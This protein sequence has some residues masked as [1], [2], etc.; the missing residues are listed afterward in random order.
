MLNAATTRLEAK[1]YWI[2][3]VKL[4]VEDH[5]AKV[6]VVLHLT[7]APVKAWQ[8]GGPKRVYS[9]HQKYNNQNVGATARRNLEN[10]LAYVTN[11]ESPVNFLTSVLNATKA[12][13]K[14]QRR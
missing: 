14:Y 8:V 4:T 2:R 7:P 12:Y 5:G 3:Q 1:G 13:M 10:L 9:S 6:L 11:D